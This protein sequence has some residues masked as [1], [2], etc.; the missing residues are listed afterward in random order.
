MMEGVDGVDYLNR[1]QIVMSNKVQFRMG[2]TLNKK[3]NMHIN[4]TDFPSNNTSPRDNEAM[5]QT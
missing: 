1:P 2:S 5:E 3:Q 4:H